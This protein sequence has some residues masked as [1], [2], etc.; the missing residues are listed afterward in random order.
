MYNIYSQVAPKKLYSFWIN[1]AEATG[2]KELKDL[3]GI[4]ESEQI[5]QAIREYLRKKGVTC[6][7]ETSASPACANTQTRLT[8]STVV[9][10]DR[11]ASF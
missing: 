1:D 6:H 9:P 2:L 3:E 11:A 7:L 5:R 4:S 10:V 8:P